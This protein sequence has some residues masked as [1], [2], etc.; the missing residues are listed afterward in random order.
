MS[1]N[2]V[3]GTF[4]EKL[5]KGFGEKKCGGPGVFECTD[6]KIDF[7]NLVSI[8]P[9]SPSNE[10]FQQW[11]TNRSISRLTSFRRHEN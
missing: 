2:D 7:P 4:L 8:F 10:E 5:M 9:A 1:E 6:V 11:L 3:E